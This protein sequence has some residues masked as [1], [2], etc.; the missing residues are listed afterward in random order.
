MGFDLSG[1]VVAEKRG[2]PDLAG[3]TI[4]ID[5]YNTIYQFLSSVRMPDG[6]PLTDS[7]GRVVSHLSGILQRTTN[8]L[9]N[10]VQPVFVF[11]GVPHPLKMETLIARKERKV[12][13][14][15]EYQEALAAGDLERARSKAMQTTRI[16][17]DIILSSRALLSAMG[18]PYLTAPSEGEA[19]AS[20]MASKGDVWGAGSQDFD[21]LLFG[22]PRLVRNMTISGRRKLPR[23]QRYVEVFP[24][25]I[26]LDVVL[27]E[28]E[29]DREQ[30]V[31]LAVLAGTD[32]NPGIKGIGPK[33]GLKLIKQHGD[34]RS[35]IADKEYDIPDLDEII[36]LF[37]DPEVTDD[38]ELDW[39]APDEARMIELLCEGHEFSRSR[40]E[41]SMKKM[42]TYRDAA[43]Q[44][45][46]EDFF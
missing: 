36:S 32:F 37:L 8:L 3:K 14:E 45:S 24:E 16:T 12:K 1:L 35:V 19:Q 39:P 6:S 41:S 13:A 4:A 23:Q 15:T 7:R 26:H 31:G 28:L 38:Y 30:L 2:I 43:S 17:D 40:V 9:A 5:A 44:K 34:I 42:Q 21:S 46:L 20:Y 25:V 11:D 18:I 33:K 27:K 29:I 22:A 10:G